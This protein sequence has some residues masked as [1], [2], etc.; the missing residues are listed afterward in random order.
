VGALIVEFIGEE[1]PVAPTDQFTFGRNGDLEV[2]SNPYLHRRLGIFAYDA[3]L[4]WTLH[5]VGSSIAIDLSDASST[6]RMTVAPGSSVALSFEE[7]T[8]AFTAG[9][10]SYELHIEVPLSRPP[11][12]LGA[13]PTGTQTISVSDMLLTP[14]QRRCLVGLA[15][16]RLRDRHASYD[17]IPTNRQVAARLDWKITKFNRKLD[18]VCDKF[19]RAGVPGLRGDASSLATRRRERLV[20]HALTVGI[21]TEADL[22]FLD[23]PT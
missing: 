1:Y 20:D 11:V 8:L 4:G 7:C 14:D 18:N 15:E 23:P 13:P 2:D 21:V 3:E 17:D 10:S 9:P 5:N 22:D 19:T 12:A 6:S 16:N